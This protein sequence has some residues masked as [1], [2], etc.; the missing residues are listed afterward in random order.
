MV[1][2]INK[3]IDCYKETVVMGLTARQLIF[4]CAVGSGGRRHCASALSAYRL[5][6]QCL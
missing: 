5:N 2:E 1:I 4:F 3:D 6:I